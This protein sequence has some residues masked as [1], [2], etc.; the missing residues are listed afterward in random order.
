MGFEG[1][2]DD[3]VGQHAKDVSE[4]V[5]HVPVREEHGPLYRAGCRFHPDVQPRLTQSWPCCHLP[6]DSR[7]QRRQQR[8]MRRLEESETGRTARVV[9]S[10]SCLTDALADGAWLAEGVKAQDLAAAAT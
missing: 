9:G 3:E 8:V 4:V 1:V 2:C 5:A 6:T 10:S 7:Q